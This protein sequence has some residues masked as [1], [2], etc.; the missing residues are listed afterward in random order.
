MNPFQNPRDYF[1]R[2]KSIQN[3]LLSYLDDENNEKK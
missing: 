2:M 1:E 3:D